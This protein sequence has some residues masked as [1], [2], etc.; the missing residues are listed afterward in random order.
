MKNRFAFQPRYF[1][2]WL[3]F[4]ELSR[5]LFLGYQHG[6]AAELPWPTLLATF[7]YGLRLDASAAAYVCILPFLLLIISSLLPRLPLQKVLSG[8]SV[9]IGLMLAL[10]ITADLE[11]YRAWGFR[12]DDTPLQYLNSPVEMAASAGD[13]TAGTVR[14][15]PGV[16]RRPT[17]VRRPSST[18]P[19]LR[20]KPA[21]CG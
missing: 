2:F 1:L 6:A 8:Y 3:L 19:Q 16:W 9:V 14:A 21:F 12:L 11:L 5:A 18:A 10:L 4:F 17:Q 15:G 20:R 13:T 7:G